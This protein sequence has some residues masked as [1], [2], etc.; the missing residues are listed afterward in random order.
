MFFAIQIYL[1]ENNFD[2]IKTLIKKKQ[3]FP[4]ND[5]FKKTI[6][7]LNYFKIEKII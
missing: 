7:I 6:K 4:L 2:A 1:E 5:N 3:I